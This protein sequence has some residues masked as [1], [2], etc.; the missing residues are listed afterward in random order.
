M[1][2][3]LL[4]EEEAIKVLPNYG[5]MYSEE[6]L[7]ELFAELRACAKSQTQCPVCHDKL[8]GTPRDAHVWWSKIEELFGP[9]VK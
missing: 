8:L 2:V 3:K 4:S 6:R 5:K 9:L 7:K 1:T